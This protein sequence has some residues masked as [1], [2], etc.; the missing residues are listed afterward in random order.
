MIFILMCLMSDLW[1]TLTI[2]RRDYLKFL[3]L[4]IIFQ[5]IQ[6]MAITNFIARD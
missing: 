6:N 1:I 5:V 2:S 3:I 4:Q